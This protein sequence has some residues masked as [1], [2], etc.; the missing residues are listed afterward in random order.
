MAEQ[1]QKAVLAIRGE[2]DEEDS[3]AVKARAFEGFQTMLNCG[4]V[5]DE[6][7]ELAMEKGDVECMFGAV[8]GFVEIEV[9]LAIENGAIVVP[10]VDFNLFY[11]HFLAFQVALFVSEFVAAVHFFSLKKIFFLFSIYYFFSEKGKMPCHFLFEYYAQSNVRE[12]QSVNGSD[13]NDLRDFFK[14]AAKVNVII[15]LLKARVTGSRDDLV[16]FLQSLGCDSLKIVFVHEVRVETEL[17]KTEF[18]LMA[19]DIADFIVGCSPEV[20]VMTRTPYGFNGSGPPINSPYVFNANDNMFD[21]VT[22]RSY[23][24]DTYADAEKRVAALAVD[25]KLSTQI[26]EQTKKKINTFA[27]KSRSMFDS[28]NPI[29]DNVES[30]LKTIYEQSIVAV[31]PGNI[32]ACSMDS[33]KLGKNSDTGMY[34]ILSDMPREIPSFSKSGNVFGNVFGEFFLPF[35]TT[36]DGVNPKKYNSIAALVEKIARAQNES[37]KKSYRDATKK[38]VD[39]ETLKSLSRSIELQVDREYG[40]GLLVKEIESFKEKLKVLINEGIGFKEK[41]KNLIDQATVFSSLKKQLVTFIPPMELSEIDFHGEGVKEQLRTTYLVF[42]SLQ[43]LCSFLVIVE[44][45]VI[46]ILKAD[47]RE[48]NEIL[49]NETPP[50]TSKHHLRTNIEKV[51]SEK[52]LKRDKIKATKEALIKF[53]EEEEEKEKM[54]KEKEEREKLE[55]EKEDQKKQIEDQRLKDEAK[56]L[57]EE[58]E[59]LEARKK[60]EGLNIGSSAAKNDDND[61]NISESSDGKRQEQ[62]FDEMFGFLND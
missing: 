22:S 32:Y 21:V 10:F 45:D 6:V 46:D 37:Y 55:K 4:P 61:G 2:E 52:E 26:T 20:R 60:L 50:I 39:G 14:M 17:D 25:K 44:D 29:L 56:K 62:L 49:A 41:L 54:E 31:A 35:L 59:K 18:D 57:E 51:I 33:V 58:R 11:E 30:I 53:D 23:K 24:S 42:L 7:V 3:D 9:I 34:A 15:V 43:Y 40:F 28:I 13:P 8:I 5:D 48:L 47:E 19:N 16:R 12:L 38:L 1:C 36:Q 27:E